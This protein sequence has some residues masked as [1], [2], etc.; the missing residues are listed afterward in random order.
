MTI[1]EILSPFDITVGDTQKEKLDAFY[2]LLIE[3]NE[4]MNLTAITDYN[5]V[6]V[7]HFADSII[8][9]PYMKGR[10][11]DVG[12]GAGF[13]SIPLAVMGVD[14]L[15]LAD[16][17]AKRISFLNEVI[18]KL[19]LSCTA[20]HIRAEDMGRGEYRESFD[21]VTARAVA[22][23]QT[24]VEYLLPLVKVGGRAVLYKSG[25][26]DEELQSSEFAI[27]RLGG[28]IEKVVRYELCG[29]ERTL[30]IIS[31]ISSTPKA[32]PRSGNK[33]RTQPLTKK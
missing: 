12:A 2:S 3:W 7:K 6:T 26:V 13:P 25:D 9:L 5:D 24:L 20:L 22:H 21:T 16:S 32:Y 23:T 4:K 30:V 18:D 29:M 8:G 33:P 17:L 27:A 1:Q 10:V 14:S 19:D 15:V 31:K 11:C 28:K